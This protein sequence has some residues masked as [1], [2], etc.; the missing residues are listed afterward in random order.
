MF[1][2]TV[3]LAVSACT[4]TADANHA[5]ERVQSLVRDTIDAA[6]GAWTSTS[7]G[8]ATDPCTKPDGGRGVWFS[9]DQDAA[10]PSDREEVMQHAWRDEGLATKTESVGRVDGKTLHRVASARRDVNSIQFNATR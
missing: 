4:T 8:P 2:L 9:W 1:I 6:G 10:G 5:S 3:A 7:N